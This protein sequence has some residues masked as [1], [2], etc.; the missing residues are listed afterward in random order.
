MARLSVDRRLRP[1]FT[2]AIVI[3]LTLGLVQCGR[4]GT[5]STPITTTSPVTIVPDTD[6]ASV[7]TYHYDNSR[8]GIQ[9]AETSL[10]P[11]NVNS[12]T[13]GKQFSVTVDGM[14]NA[15]P[16]IAK[17]ITT[18]DG[19]PHTLLIVATENDSV[20]AFDADASS[21][22]PYWQVS[23][24]QA[25]ETAVPA[26][27]VNSTDITPAVGVVGTPVIDPASGTLYLVSKAKTSAGGYVQRI[28]ALKL[29]DGSE[30]MNGP[31][32]IAATIAGTASDA[33][34]GMVSFNALRENQRA[35]LALNNGT[36]WVTWS[37]HTDNGPYHG[38]I[39]GYKSSDVSQQTNVFNDTPNG[40]EGGIWMSAGGPAF[41]TSNNM[42]VMTGNG[43]FS[44]TAG[45]Y[46]S[47]ALKLNA[48]TSPNGSLAI[49]DY[50]TPYNQA[51]LSAV[52]ADFGVSS[53]ILL[54]D[55]AGPHP[56]LLVTTDKDS[57]IYL[58]DRDNMGKYSTTT[59]NVVQN[60]YGSIANIK[61][62]LLFF[63]NTLYISGD[64]SPM[65]AFAFNP[66]T[67]LFNTTPSS[68]T[69][70]SFTCQNGCY[71]GGSAPTISENGATN[72]ILWTVDNTAFKVP[73]PAILRA[74]NPSDLTKELYDSAQAANG[75]DAAADAVKFTTPVIA[76]GHVYVAGVNSVTV[77]GLLSQ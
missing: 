57:D 6:A 27:D 66:T 38:W 24:L 3:P 49:A 61:Q 43:D 40:A 54:P 30:T 23:L 7:S 47:S 16:L 67:G 37:S 39:L 19:Q 72:A 15:Q 60:F 13:F 68:V 32:T 14:V 53:G 64:N 12:T 25:G 22:T 28:H 48:G 70:E 36:V 56:H 33:S 35:A 73:G 34:G 76:N 41:D 11:A 10:T 2:V 46:S 21:T 58:I 20:Y 8:S 74:Y 26:G 18:S 65:N 44:N 77:Y 31:T 50:F 9:S 63:N 62:N 29:E 4:S 71:V 45:N 17:N 5:A 1:V 69:S 55:Q 42:F 59:N 75:R 52:D 51:S